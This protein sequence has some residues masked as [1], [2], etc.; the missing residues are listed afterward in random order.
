V[1]IKNNIKYPLCKQ[2]ALKTSLFAE[3]I[4]CNHHAP[5]QGCSWRYWKNPLFFEKALDIMEIFQ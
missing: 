4:T 2:K 3:T 5:E 1:F